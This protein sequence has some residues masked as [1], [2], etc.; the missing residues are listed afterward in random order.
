MELTQR[1]RAVNCRSIALQGV[2]IEH[3]S[4][5]AQALR[6]AEAGKVLGS[7]TLTSSSTSGEAC[8][9]PDSSAL[10]PTPK[11]R[12]LFLGPPDYLLL[13]LFQDHQKTSMLAAGAR[14]FRGASD[15]NSFG[16]AVACSGS[17]R[18]QTRVSARINS[19]RATRTRPRVG[20][21]TKSWRVSSDNLPRQPRC[22]AVNKATGSGRSSTTSRT[23]AVDD[24]GRQPT[25]R[26]QSIQTESAA[27]FRRFWRTSHN[28]SAST[29]C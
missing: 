6:R 15:P 11:A 21:Q 20:R 10:I 1:Q 29:S 2:I 23:A 8:G 16:D 22:P 5:V 7:A 27:S 25:F 12:A 9:S 3:F 17:L 19:K 26:T 14:C 28:G 24:A 4:T 13:S 18:N